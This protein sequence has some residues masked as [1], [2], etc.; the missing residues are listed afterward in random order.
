MATA[1]DLR[2]VALSLEGTTE[3]PHFDRT[4]FKV[5]RIYVTLAADGRTANLMFTPDEQALKCTVAPDAF[6]ALPNKWGEKGATC[7]T[8]SKLKVA[9]LR[10]ALE[11]AYQHAL[12]RKAQRPKL[13]G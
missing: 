10:S 3:A 8:L 5:A 6:A 13:P 1:D 12:P 2:R 7:A 11:M 4:A 9:E